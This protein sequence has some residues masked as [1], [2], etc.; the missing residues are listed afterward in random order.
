M[1]RS[2]LLFNRTNKWFQLLIF[3]MLILMSPF[4]I[5]PTSAYETGLQQSDVQ[6]IDFSHQLCSCKFMSKHYDWNYS[7]TPE[8]ERIPLFQIKHRLV[9]SWKADFY[10]TS[11]RFRCVYE[12]VDS[13]GNPE[14]VEYVQTETRPGYYDGGVMAAKKFHCSASTPALNRKLNHY[15][16]EDAISFK[17]YQSKIDAIQNWFQKKCL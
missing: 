12:C 13:Y 16:T 14:M 2:I 17:A 4:T 5:R 6:Q 10:E 9:W 7:N 8:A 15:Q 3:S 1:I 11:S